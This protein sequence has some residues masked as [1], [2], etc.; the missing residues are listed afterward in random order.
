LG[1]ENGYTVGWVRPHNARLIAAAPELLEA[2]ERI[3]RAQ[4]RCAGDNPLDGVIDDARA[5]LAKAKGDKS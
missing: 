2:L 4:E 1:A 3:C 5:A